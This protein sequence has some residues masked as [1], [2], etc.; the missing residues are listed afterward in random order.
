MK[1]ILLLAVVCCTMVVAQAQR[2][3]FIYLQ[4]DNRSPFYLK[5][6]DKVYSST[7]HGYLIVPRLA[8]STYNVVIGK[9][10]L[11]ESRFTIPVNGKDHGFLLRQTGQQLSLFNL[12][13]MTVIEAITGNSGGV[14]YIDKTDR[15][16]TLLAQAA[17]DTTLLKMAVFAKMEKPAEQVE[18][19][20]KAEEVKKEET[21]VVQT[22]STDTVAVIAAAEEPIVVDTV[23]TI[24]AATK[25]R[26]K[27]EINKKDTA[28]TIAAK[29]EPAKEAIKAEPVQAEP[30]VSDAEETVYKRSVVTRRAESSTS[31]GFGL[32]FTDNVDGVIDTIRIVIPNPKTPF[33][34]P[35]IAKE[36]T[37]ED[38]RFLELDKTAPKTSDK[39]SETDKEES[40]KKKGLFGF[41]KQ[42]A[43]EKANITAKEMELK[44]A[45]TKETKDSVQEDEQMKKGLFGFRK[46]ADK[47]AGI[48]AKEMELKKSDKGAATQI[49]E[50]AKVV[51]T[52]KNNASNSDFARLRRSMVGKTS[53][54]EM[55]GEAQK[56]FKN[57]CFTT[58][59]IKTLSSLLLTSHGR[60]QLFAAAYNHV[61][62]KENFRSL[63]NELWDREDINRFKTLLA[64]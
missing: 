14:S 39:E 25:E 19:V 33:R 32:M 45:E 29:E 2:V 17:D 49:D 16:T 23:A 24:A 28:Q 38:V 46:Q 60:Y 5:T 3:Y 26:E 59:Q 30:V 34:E 21:A 62:D 36:N 48:T 9:P 10:G 56:A 44:R 63:Q 27:E 6:G 57:K 55:V 1:K 31:E 4:S 64:K 54:D 20:A 52:C 8:D 7:A 37:M 15:F 40:Q 53:E 13:S 43:D 12:Q 42:E 41:R 58:E 47:E 51:E 11:A 18:A 22:E 35:D 50:P 61:S